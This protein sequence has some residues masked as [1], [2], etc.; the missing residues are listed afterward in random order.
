MAELFPQRMDHCRRTVR[1]ASDMQQE[2][3][4]LAEGNSSSNPD[5]EV[6]HVRD[7]IAMVMAR[8]PGNSG[9]PAAAAAAAVGLDLSSSGPSHKTKMMGETRNSIGYGFAST[10][11]IA[12]TIKED[13]NSYGRAKR[14]LEGKGKGKGR[15]GCCLRATCLRV[16][17]GGGVDTGPPENGPAQPFRLIKASFPGA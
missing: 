15:G 8:R 16:Q 1:R 11:P 7:I 12:N 2:A 9:T 17:G 5:T 3:V 13:D 4:A 14:G 10:P 6:T